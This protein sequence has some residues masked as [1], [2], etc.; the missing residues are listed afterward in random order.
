[1]ALVKILRAKD[2]V[3]ILGV[4]AP[5]IHR[6]RKQGLIPKPDFGGNGLVARWLPKTIM[7]FYELDELPEVGNERVERN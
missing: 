6:W 2:L 5:T 1:M 4:S 7:E 3:Q